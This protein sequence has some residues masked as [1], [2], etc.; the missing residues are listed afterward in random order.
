MGW[1]II[2]FGGTRKRGELAFANE[3]EAG[4]RER[5]AADDVDDVM[6]MR[7]QRRERDQAKPSHDDDSQNA[8]RV[9]SVKIDK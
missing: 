2:E 3:N 5:G 7:E 8:A 9:A 4:G 1:A 6:L